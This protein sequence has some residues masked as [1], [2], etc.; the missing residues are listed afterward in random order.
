VFWILSKSFSPFL[1]SYRVRASKEE[2]IFYRDVL[3]FW[4]FLRWSLFPLLTDLLSRIKGSVTQQNAPFWTCLIIRITGIWYGSADPDP[5]LNV[6]DPQH[7]YCTVTVTVTVPFCLCG[8]EEELHAGGEEG[9]KVAR[10]SFWRPGTEGS[11]RK[12]S[13]VQVPYRFIAALWNRN[14]NYLLRF[15]FHIYTVFFNVNRSSIDV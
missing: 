13:G 4:C 12:G 8:Q 2:N 5:Y 9:A 6:T 10:S 15:R 7:C 14:R 3:N 11:A 1:L